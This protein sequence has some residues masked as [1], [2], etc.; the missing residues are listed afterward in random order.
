MAKVLRCREVGVDCDFE[1]RGESEE[2]ILQKCAEHAKSAHGTDEIPP[3]LAAK[4]SGAIREEDSQGA[5]A[6]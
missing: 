5:A 3:E 6:R 4:V 2:E 1:A